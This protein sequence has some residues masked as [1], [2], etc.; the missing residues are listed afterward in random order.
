MSGFWSFSIL[1]RIIAD[2]AQRKDT[3]TPDSLEKYYKCSPE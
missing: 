1:K 3:K 2:E